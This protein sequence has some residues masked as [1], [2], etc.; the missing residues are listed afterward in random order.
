MPQA[1]PL[2][3]IAYGLT[4]NSG[5]NQAQALTDGA[6]RLNDGRPKTAIPWRSTPPMA[7]VECAHIPTTCR[8]HQVRQAGLGGRGDQQ[9]DLG[10][11]QRVGMDDHVG[12]DRRFTQTSEVM[13]TINGGDEHCLSA[14]AA[15]NDQVGL[16]RKD[17]TAKSSHR[18]CATRR[19]KVKRAFSTYVLSLRCSAKGPD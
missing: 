7:L 13:F 8:L 15:M 17:D 5:F 11:Q 19:L 3:L 1:G 6:T 9:P 12:I 4:F 16:P 10:V 18:R 2:S 14:L